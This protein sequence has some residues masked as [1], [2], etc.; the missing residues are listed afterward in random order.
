MILFFIIFILH[1]TTAQKTIAANSTI[2]AKV[3][4]VTE[5]QSNVTEGQRSVTEGQRSVT[6]GQ[7][8]VTKGQKVRNTIDTYVETTTKGQ[9]SSGQ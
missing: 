4:N 1:V 3:V 6:E 9:F 8:G 2:A 5:D 7:R